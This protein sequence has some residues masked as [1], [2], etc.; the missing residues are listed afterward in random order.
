V[1]VAGGSGGEHDLVRRAAASTTPLAYN[2]PWALLAL[3]LIAPVA[4]VAANL[5][6]AWP[7][8]RAAR[9]RAGQILR[10]E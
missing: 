1:H 3:L 4:L 9:L 8:R 10:T 2:T 5:L 6:A 7:A